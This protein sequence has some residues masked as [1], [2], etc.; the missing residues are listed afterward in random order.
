MTVL[1]LVL[2]VKGGWGE[3]GRGGGGGEAEGRRGR[4]GGEADV[5]RAVVKNGLY[6]GWTLLYLSHHSP[7]L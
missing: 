3:R 6:N 4:R 7:L 1:L 5:V 2:Q